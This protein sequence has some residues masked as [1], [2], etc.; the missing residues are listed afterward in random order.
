M[1]GTT[2]TRRPYVRCNGREV[3]FDGDRE[4]CLW[5]KGGSGWVDTDSGSTANPRMAPPCSGCRLCIQPRSCRHEVPKKHPRS[6][7]AGSSGAAALRGGGV[8]VM[9]CSQRGSGASFCVGGVKMGCPR[10]RVA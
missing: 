8:T 7:S 9:V 2:E 5:G 4:S 1:A 10:Y 6:R 3:I